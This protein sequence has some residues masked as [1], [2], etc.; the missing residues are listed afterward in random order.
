MTTAEL[1]RTPSDTAAPALQM[2][3]ADL[4]IREF[5]R[6]AGIRGLISRAAFDEGFAMHCL[7]VESFGELA[8]KPFRI[9]VPSGR[10]Q[11]TNTLYGYA[12]CA[13]DALQNAAATYA[14][15]QQTRILLP[16]RIHSK[17]MPTVWQPGK[18]LG[19]EILVRPTI[20]RGRGSDRAGRECDAFQAEAERH[21][22][23][24]MP[25]S[26]EEVYADWLKERLECKG[27]AR[28]KEATLAMFQR[29]RAIRKLHDRPSEGPH[30]LMRGTLTITDPTEF[31]SLLASGVGRHKAY[32]YGML[33][34]RPPLNAHAR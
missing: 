34:L 6:W 4:N 11:R 29:T 14:D 7:L 26:R 21:G 24:E 23:G 9:I 3:R 32:G 12:R 22:K 25:R 31:A 19:F 1:A 16:S 2:I 33:L 30:A 8:P 10:G 20:R 18:H 17:P 5:H 28:L 13:A 15:P 27:A